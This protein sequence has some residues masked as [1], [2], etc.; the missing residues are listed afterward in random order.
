MVWDKTCVTIS[1]CSRQNARDWYRKSQM[2]ILAYSSL[3]R[4]LLSGRINSSMI[5]NIDLYLDRFA[6]RGYA[7]PENYERLKRCELLAQKKGASVAQIALA[8]I[9]HQGMNMFAVVNTSKAERMRENI[10]AFNIL[11]SDEE[12]LFLDLEVDRLM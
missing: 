12:C 3:G 2:P 10:G 8:W 1:G 11:L 4:G 7:Y 5:E 9:F 6:Q